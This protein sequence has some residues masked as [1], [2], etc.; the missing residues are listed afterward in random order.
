MATA[1]G[2]V[3]DHRNLV[4]IGRFIESSSPNGILMVMNLFIDSAKLDEYV[5]VV[6]PVVKKMRANA[7]CLFCEVSVNPHDK[8]HV[9]VLH[10]WTRDSAWFR[11][12]SSHSRLAY[13][14]P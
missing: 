13:L 8:G 2:Q 4:P 12:V 1:T 6:T 3:K 10:G 9:R 7:E 14:W 11:D 5:K